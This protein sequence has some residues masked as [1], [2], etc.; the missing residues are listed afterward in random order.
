M[1]FQAL[2]R[3]RPDFSNGWEN[4]FK[5][6]IAILKTTFLTGSGDVPVITQGM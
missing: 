4:Y 6:S 1:I 3:T 5:R 2:E